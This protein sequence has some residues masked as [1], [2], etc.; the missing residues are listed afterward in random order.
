MLF[1]QEFGHQGQ[2]RTDLLPNSSYLRLSQVF[3]HRACS[4]YGSA[5]HSSALARAFAI[6][7]TWPAQL[8][9]KYI[10]FYPLN[11]VGSFGLDL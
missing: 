6:N 8:Q 2:Q 7:S 5:V 9:M 11:S 3:G 4:G 1:Q 10:P